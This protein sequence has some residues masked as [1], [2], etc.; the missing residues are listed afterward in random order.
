[1]FQYNRFWHFC[2]QLNNRHY[3]RASLVSLVIS[4]LLIPAAV[5]FPPLWGLVVALPLIVGGTIALFTQL[6]NFFYNRQNQRLTQ[7]KAETTDEALKE[8]I[9]LYL[10]RR[11]VC[12]EE[13]LAGAHLNLP[14][15]TPK[16]K[17]AAADTPLLFETEDTLNITKASN[18]IYRRNSAVKATSESNQL[19]VKTVAAKDGL[20]EVAAREMAEILGFGGLIPSNTITGTD[21]LHDYENEPSI[22]N[23]GLVLSRQK[24]RELI[25]ERR[26]ESPERNITNSPGVQNAVAKFVFNLKTAAYRTKA[27]KEE[28]F[29]LL[30]V[31]KLIPNA[32]DGLQVYTQL[33]N[34]PVVLPG[35][36][37][38][39]GLTESQ[40]RQQRV[41]AKNI[42]QKISLPSFQEN[43]LLHLILGSQ[44]ANPGNTLFTDGSNDSVILH[45][46]DH[47]RIMP[48]DNYNITKK[49]PLANGTNLASI[50]EKDVENVFPIRLWLAGLPQANVP[51]TKEVI[52]KTIDSLNPE[53]LLAYH[54]QKKLFSSAAVGAQLE[55]ILLIKNTFEEEIKKSQIT[56]TPKQLFLKLINNHPSYIFLKNELQLSELSTF[57]LLGQIPEG[58]D[59]SLLRHPLQ[60]FSMIG[61]IV[62]AQL[63]ELQG[64][65]SFSEES[66]KSSHAHHVLFFSLANQ[67]KMAEGANKAGLDILSEASAHLGLH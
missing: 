10:N 53:R 48:E 45:S 34:E 14:H 4:L 67:Q 66:F 18:D 39:G 28:Q 55:R 6:S 61:M 11:V 20:S 46:I 52:E 40:K 43:F 32:L 58:A 24:I 62:E 59:M 36:L 1:M 38:L 16:M 56:L 42:V 2:F 63:N 37:V 30:H 49:I 15:D 65:P 51:F 60:W 31:Q 7:L 47:E 27:Q 64:R 13:L 26:E 25:D 57:M 22:P 50:T 19:Y 23:T 21:V 33:F 35:Q 3:F 44:D 9:D 17:K 5:F 12:P 8:E 41:Q 54:H 29:K